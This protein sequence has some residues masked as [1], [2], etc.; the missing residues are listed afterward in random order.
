MFIVTQW[1]VQYYFKTR[2]VDIHGGYA[3]VQ[4]Q[5]AEQPK[6][7]QTEWLILAVFGFIAFLWVTEN[8]IASWKV[9]GVK[10]HNESLIGSSLPSAAAPPRLPDRVLTSKKA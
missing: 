8:V 7:S 9:H 2:A 3:A 6:M 4:K 1:W 5:H 10:S